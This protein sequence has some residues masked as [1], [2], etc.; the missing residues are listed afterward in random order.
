MSEPTRTGQ[1]KNKAL[2]TSPVDDDIV[3]LVAVRDD[4]SHHSI[5][6]K[7]SRSMDADTIDSLLKRGYVVVAKTDDRG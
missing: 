1:L 2:S 3:E 6:A 7:F 5:T 4:G